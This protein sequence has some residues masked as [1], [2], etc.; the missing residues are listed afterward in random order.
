MISVNEAFNKIDG[1]KGFVLGAIILVLVILDMTVFPKLLTD[2]PLW[3]QHLP[4]AIFFLT[5][6]VAKADYKQIKTKK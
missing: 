2:A 5:L 3:K 4:Q 1:K 6:M